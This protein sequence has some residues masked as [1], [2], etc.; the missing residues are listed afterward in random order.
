MSGS[1]DFGEVDGIPVVAVDHNQD[2]S[3]DV[4]L[5]N[6]TKYLGCWLK[7]VIPLSPG[8]DVTIQEIHLD[9]KDIKLDVVAF[10]KAVG[11]G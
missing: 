4:T 2:G 8:P 7:S 11:Y 1:L 9:T 6:G 10:K 5:A 3:V